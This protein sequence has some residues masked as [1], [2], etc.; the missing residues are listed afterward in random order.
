[1]KAYEIVDE[2][3]NSR[4]PGKLVKSTA[5]SHTIHAEI[6]DRIIAY[7]AYLDVGS[8]DQRVLSIEFYERPISDTK[9]TP[10]Y[11]KTGSGDAMKVF[12]FIIDCVKDSI[13]D[14]DPDLITFSS[15][16]EDGNRSALYAKI[17]SR[18]KIPGYRLGKIDDARYDDVFNIVKDK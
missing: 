17:V 12:S 15:S 14:Y 10:E 9:W 13:I 4:V 5:N 2:S 18:V 11:G 6:G 3:F 1:M 8:T 16:K 7:H